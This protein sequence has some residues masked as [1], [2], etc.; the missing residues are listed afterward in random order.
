M[1]GKNLNGVDVSGPSGSGTRCGGSSDSESVPNFRVGF[2]SG[3]SQNKKGFVGRVLCHV[4]GV[5]L[6]I[7]V[8]SD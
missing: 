2:A 5:M 7:F 6:E 3:H 8:G 4:Y 1:V